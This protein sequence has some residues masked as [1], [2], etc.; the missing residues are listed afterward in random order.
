MA[1]TEV[2]GRT[3]N[4]VLSGLDRNPDLLSAKPA[5]SGLPALVLS[6]HDGLTMHTASAMAGLVIKALF[7]IR[8]PIQTGQE[9]GSSI[10]AR[11]GLGRSHRIH[12][13]ADGVPDRL[14]EAP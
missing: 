5:Q 8:I 4:F 14:E 2:L 1:R 10:C 6:A 13:L 12:G 9:V 11:S 7:P 3:I